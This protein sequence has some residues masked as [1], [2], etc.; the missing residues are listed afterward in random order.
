[1]TPDFLRRRPERRADL[2]REAGFALRSTAVG[3]PDEALGETS[4][5]AFLPA[6]RRPGAEPVAG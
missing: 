2:L 5:Q 1:M 3:E 4:P 6:A